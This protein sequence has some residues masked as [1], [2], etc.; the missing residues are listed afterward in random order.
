[1]TSS[2][3]PPWG[4]PRPAAGA[5]SPKQLLLSLPDEDSVLRQAQDRLVAGSKL[6]LAGLVLLAQGEVEAVSVLV[7]FGVLLGLEKLLTIYHSRHY[8]TEFLPAKPKAVLSGA[9]HPAT[10]PDGAITP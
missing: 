8:V 10:Q 2:P 6:V 9:T 3:P 4:T 1:M 7:M 5:R